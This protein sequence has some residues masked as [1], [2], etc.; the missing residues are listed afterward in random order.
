[1]RANRVIS[2]L[3]WVDT[4]IEGLRL[5]FTRDELMERLQLAIDDLSS[6]IVSQ[7]GRIA[8]LNNRLSS[9]SVASAWHGETQSEINQ[10]EGIIDTLRKSI[11]NKEIIMSH[12]FN[13]EY[14]LTLDDLK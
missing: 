1:M 12:L 10:R 3:G 14:S 8:N 11:L 5:K 7:E 9:I 6:R 13:D 4:M 2:R